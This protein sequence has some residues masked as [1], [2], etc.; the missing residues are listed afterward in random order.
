MK[1]CGP[2][3]AGASIAI[4]DCYELWE[5]GFISIPY[6]FQVCDWDARLMSVEWLTAAFV[7]EKDPIASTQHPSLC[8]S[9]AWS[10]R[11]YGSANC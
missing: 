9:L 7:D 8:S 5:S 11:A 1:V 4:D 2:R 3:L 10:Q 6:N